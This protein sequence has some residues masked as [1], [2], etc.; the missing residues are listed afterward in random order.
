MQIS[1]FFFFFFPPHR[2]TNTHT[3]RVKGCPFFFPVVCGKFYYQKENPA[4][5]VPGRDSEVLT[6]SVWGWQNNKE[7]HLYKVTCQHS[8]KMSPISVCLRF[9]C[10]S[11]SKDVDILGI[12]N[13]CRHHE[14]STWCFGI[15]LS[16]QMAVL[17][18]LWIDVRIKDEV[19]DHRGW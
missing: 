4:Q 19:I 8:L 7:A 11:L 14:S 6:V 5:Y 3:H 1:F 13:S 16:D 10:H 2:N 12:P 9:I 15:C 18:A 17:D